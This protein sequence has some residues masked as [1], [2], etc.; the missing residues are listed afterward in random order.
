MS[1]PSESTRSADRVRWSARRSACALTRLVGVEPEGRRPR[2]GSWPG[3]VNEA[4][5]RGIASRKPGK[6]KPWSGRLD[7]LDRVRASAATFALEVSVPS[8]PSSLLRLQ[9]ARPAA[10]DVDPGGELEPARVGMRGGRARPVDDDQRVAGPVDEQTA[11][12]DPELLR[13]ERVVSEHRVPAVAEPG[14]VERAAVRGRV[15]EH[16]RDSGRHPAVGRR[17]LLEVVEAVEILVVEPGVADD[18]AVPGRRGRS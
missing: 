10:L 11:V 13:L 7:A 2:R 8:N 16:R 3:V 18:P 17:R 5:H 14:G 12:R 15:G 6:T 4:V 9:A 1:V